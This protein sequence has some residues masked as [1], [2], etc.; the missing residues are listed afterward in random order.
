MCA[1]SFV[2]PVPGGWYLGIPCSH[3]DEMVLF[4][5]DLSCGEGTLSFL[6]ADEAVRERCVSGHLTSFRLEELKRFQWQPA[7]RLMSRRRSLKARFRALGLRPPL[8]ARTS[9]GAAGS[10]GR[11]I[12]SYRRE[13]GDIR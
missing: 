4:A 12:A 10:G 11:E 3:C 6:E 7:A 2:Q 9:S 13:D 5:V 1:D 8:E